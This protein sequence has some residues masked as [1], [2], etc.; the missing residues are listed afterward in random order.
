MSIKLQTFLL[1]PLH[2][3]LEVDYGLVL[4]A[5]EF[6]ER[7]VDERIVLRGLA[8]GRVYKADRANF[9]DLANLCVD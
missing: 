8:L 5:I 7:S 6:L 9:N 1:C 4:I 2:F 3:I